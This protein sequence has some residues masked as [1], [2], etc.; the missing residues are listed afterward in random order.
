MAGPIVQ[1]V[2]GRTLAEEM[3][4]RSMKRIG[5]RHTCS[6]A[7][8]D[9][10]IR[11]PH[12]QRYQR[13]PAHGPRRDFTELDPSAG[14]AAGQLISTNSDLNRFFTALLAGHL[15]PAAPLA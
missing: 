6:R 10:T 8:G 12:P 9:M 1:K 13:N 4:R 5:L 3:D 14:C 7:P 15:L 11:E 2:S